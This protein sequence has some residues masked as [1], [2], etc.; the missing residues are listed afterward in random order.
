MIRK[1]RPKPTTVEA[2]QFTKDNTDDCVKFIG[3]QDIAACATGQ[4]IHMR[5]HLGR[6]QIDVGDYI[7]KSQYGSA[8]RMTAYEFENNFE[9]AEAAK[10]RGK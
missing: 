6:I 7:V 9:A 1:Y 10:A 8:S 2:L 3:S 5:T 4:Y